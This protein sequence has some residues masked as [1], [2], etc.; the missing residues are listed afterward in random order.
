MLLQKKKK[1]KK[2]SEMN[3]CVE[4]RNMSH[5][6][7]ALGKNCFKGTPRLFLFSPNLPP[8][9]PAPHTREHMKL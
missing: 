7:C 3:G 6:V 1:K 9:H 4:D 2:M 8:T 5:N